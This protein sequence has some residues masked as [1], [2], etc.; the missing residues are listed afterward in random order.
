MRSPA[1]AAAEKNKFF[2]LIELLVVIGVIAILAS[3]LMPALGSA[4][5]TAKTLQC[6]NTCRNVWSAFNMYTE[7]YRGYLPW[8]TSGD[9][10]AVNLFGPSAAGSDF[11][12]IT[13]ILYLFYLKP[14]FY[15]D[16]WTRGWNPGG[17]FN[18]RMLCPVALEKKETCAKS[19]TNRLTFAFN[20]LN[21]KSIYNT[22]SPS[23]TV[24]HGEIADTLST[25]DGGGWA[26]FSLGFVPLMQRHGAKINAAFVDGHLETRL[27]KNWPVTNYNIYCIRPSTD[28]D[29]KAFWGLD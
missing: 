16:K 1:K 6:L 22:R 23:R 26:Q 19:N 18:Q 17:N 7:D 25:I 28:N 29:Y 21:G 20:K 27:F 13:D 11:G 5:R 9:I 14:S 2:T 8:N 4:K 12:G 24:L 10:I 3:L 15:R